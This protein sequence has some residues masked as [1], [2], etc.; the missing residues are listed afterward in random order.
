MSNPPQ[1]LYAMR[2][3]PDCTEAF[4]SIC[5]HRPRGRRLWQRSA[6][7]GCDRNRA[8]S[9]LNTLSGWKL[10]PLTRDFACFINSEIALLCDRQ[11]AATHGDLLVGSGGHQEEIARPLEGGFVGRA[12]DLHAQRAVLEPLDPSSAPA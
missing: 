10:E 11:G 7:T 4:R 12:L 5:A 2:R 1:E 6:S 8:R 9:P 3:K